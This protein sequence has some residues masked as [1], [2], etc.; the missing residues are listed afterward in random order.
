MTAR[1]PRDRQLLRML[2]AIVLLAA[3]VY[4]ASAALVGRPPVIRDAFQYNASAQR[5]LNT[6]VYEYNPD[7]T[8]GIEATN[9]PSAFTMPGYTVFL[10]G[11][12][13]FFPHSGDVVANIL[14]AQNAI[15]IIQLLLAVGTA[16]VIAYAGHQL[17]GPTLGW[18]AGALAVAYVPFGMNATVTLTETL[19][20]AL[21]S[22]VVLATVGLLRR[23]AAS[24]PA[25]SVRWAL[26]LGIAGGTSILVRPTIA[27]WLAA[28]LLA[29]LWTHRRSPSSRWRVP[30]IVAACVVVLMTP[31]VVRNA[32]SLGRF[33]PFTDSVSTPLLDSVGGANFTAAEEDLI[34]RAEAEGRDPYQ[35]V[36]LQRLKTKWLVSPSGFLRWKA[37]SAWIG[38]GNFTNLPLDILADLQMSGTPAPRTYADAGAFLPVT[39]DAVYTRLFEG[40]TWYHRIL[41]MLAGIGVVLGHRRAAV[42]L[43]ASIPVYYAIVHTVILFMIRYFYP[44]MPALIL[45]AAFGVAGTARLVAARTTHEASTG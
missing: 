40:V 38:V 5:L 12:Y 22:V 15:I 4:G 28:P 20:L 44:A 25:R 21:M 18:T 2:M 14:T 32:V 7:L 42:W 37:E 1:A 17:G 41:L 10:A 36:A 43:L 29:W 26:L 16:T 34:A 11:I 24:D 13:L 23:G 35:A 3:I 27:L 39:S 6:G 8:A 9:G 19:A 30:M 33:V 45:L 31:W